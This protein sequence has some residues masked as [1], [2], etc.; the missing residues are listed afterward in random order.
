M[1]HAGAIIRGG[2]GTIKGKI[3]ALRKA[4]VPVAEVPWEIGDLLR[5]KGVT[6]D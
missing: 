5:D 3:E 2:S 6:G 1:G 4:G